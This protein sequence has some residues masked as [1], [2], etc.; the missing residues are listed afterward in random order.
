MQLFQTKWGQGYMIK[1][2]RAQNRTPL[3]AEKTKVTGPRT[4]Y[5]K[6]FCS[7][8]WRTTRWFYQRNMPPWVLKPGLIQLDFNLI[9]QPYYFTLM[10][11]TGR[12]FFY[13]FILYSLKCYFTFFSEHRNKEHIHKLF[14]KKFI[15]RHFFIGFDTLWYASS[16]PIRSFKIIIIYILYIIIICTI[17]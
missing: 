13:F 11:R 10:K 5:K 6:G 4:F 14:L 17:L 7:L 15:L 16:S 12:L 9:W 8:C 2:I 3:Y 1:R